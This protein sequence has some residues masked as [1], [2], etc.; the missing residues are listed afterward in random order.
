[1][2]L[3]RRTK[4]TVW[5]LVAIVALGI[6]YFAYGFYC[7]WHRFA[8]EERICGAFQPV[9]SALDRFQETTGKLPTNLT[10]LVPAYLA[11]I[12]S[13]PVADSIDYLVMSDGTNWQITV[14]SRITGPSRVYVQR[15]SRQFSDEERRETLGGFHGWEIF[16]ER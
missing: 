6:A 10:Q 3:S 14:H 4:I 11:Q 13:A 16:K 12:P 5:A 2:P 7:A 8:S 1:M 9:F 15:S